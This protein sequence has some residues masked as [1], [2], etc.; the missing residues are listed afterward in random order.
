MPQ[1]C[2]D[3]PEKPKIEGDEDLPFPDTPSTADGD[4]HAREVKLL[5]DDQ[6]HKHKTEDHKIIIACIVLGICFLIIIV[7]SIVDAFAEIASDL[8]SGAFEFAK[9]IAT[10]VIGYLFAANTSSK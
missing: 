8:F 7:F 10:A 5:E 1:P 3:P 9:T 6:K 4:S 2:L